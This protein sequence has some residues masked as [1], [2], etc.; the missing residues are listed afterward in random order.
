MIRTS[1]YDKCLQCISSVVFSGSW[2]LGR[3][4]TGSLWVGLL[5]KPLPGAALHGELW[6][7]HRW[8]GCCALSEWFIP[9][10]FMCRCSAQSC[11]VSSAT[12]APELQ[13]TLTGRGAQRMFWVSSLL[14]HGECDYFVLGAVQRCGCL[15]AVWLPLLAGHLPKLQLWIPLL[16]S[17]LF[18]W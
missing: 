10:P 4:R 2:M 1:C 9:L 3:G 5:W 12:C 18:L 15:N 16:R 13:P 17:L 8:R 14:L 11:R 6:V 7:L